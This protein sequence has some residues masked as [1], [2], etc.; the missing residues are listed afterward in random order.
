M[1]TEQQWLREQPG[2]AS[3]AQVMDQFEAMAKN[4]RQS[5]FRPMAT[6]FIPLD[7]ILNGG[8]RP[9]ELM[10]IGGPYGVGKTI[11]AL[12]MAR[13]AVLAD[14]HTKAIY[15]CYEHDRTHLLSRL[16]CLESAERDT[17]GGDSLTLRKLGKLTYSP[18]EAS[19]LISQLRRDRRYADMLRVIDT[20]A[21]RLILARASG[22]NTTLRD[23]H[24]WVEELQTSDT[25]RILVV[26]DYLQKI[27]FSRDLYLSEDELTTQ[28][29]H[30]LKELALTLGVPVIAI[31]AADRPSLKGQRMRLADLRGSSALQ[32]EADIGMVLNNKYDIVSREHL[33]YNLS[34]AESMRNWL[35]MTVEKNRAGRN[36]VDMEY[37]LD[38][39]HFR[40][41]PEGAFVRERLID[42]KA[43]LE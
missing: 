33:I 26:V 16:I 27:A 5:Q 2:P 15:I 9:G 3:V 37:A 29:A 6:G 30:G 14:P 28:L 7:E 24:R 34:D 41:M 36:T 10:V 4:G 18:V 22:S 38:G 19:G 8:M 40:I 25:S 1:S 32:Y 31:A 39:P 12:Q 42:G 17:N 35:V 11:L 21:D 23:I 13:N 20:Y 43:V